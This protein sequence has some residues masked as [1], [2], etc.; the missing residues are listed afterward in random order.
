MTPLPCAGHVTRRRNR[1]ST[2]H[3]TV[4]VTD[5]KSREA[6]RL[7][8]ALQQC[9]SHKSHEE[10]RLPAPLYATHPQSRVRSHDLSKNIRDFS[11]R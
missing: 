5:R 9:A 10:S 4:R 2:Q 11:P 3:S 1:D 7:S 6:S 8:P